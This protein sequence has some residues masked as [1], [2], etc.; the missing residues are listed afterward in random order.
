[1]QRAVL[2]AAGVVPE[3]KVSNEIRPN[4]SLYLFSKQIIQ[5]L[6]KLEQNLAKEARE[7]NRS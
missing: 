6:E 1:V 2:L 3:D 7:S 4:L 5:A